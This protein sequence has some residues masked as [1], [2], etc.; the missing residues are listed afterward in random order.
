MSTRISL[1]SLVAS[2]VVAGGL[3]AGIG[4]TSQAHAAASIAPVHSKPLVNHASARIM[5]D[6]TCPTCL[7]NPFGGIVATLA[8]VRMDLR[9]H[10]GKA[11]I[12]PDPRGCGS[13]CQSS[14]WNTIERIVPDPRA[15]GGGCIGGRIL[16]MGGEPPIVVDYAPASQVRL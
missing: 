16:R 1:S 15:C 3:F 7:H 11:R 4:A 12:V 14:R 10:P 9:V 13:G 2:L 5:P 6:P 8:H